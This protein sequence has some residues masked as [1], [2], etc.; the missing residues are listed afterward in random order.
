MTKYV[1]WKNTE[2]TLCERGVFS[3]AVLEKIQ[4]SRLFILQL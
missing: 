2:T 3:A 1:T 4:I